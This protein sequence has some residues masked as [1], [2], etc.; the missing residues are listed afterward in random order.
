M[1][2]KTRETNVPT[3]ASFNTSRLTI[4]VDYELQDLKTGKVLATDSNS[5]YGDYVPNS[6]NTKPETDMRNGLIDSITK[7]LRNSIVD[8]IVDIKH[9][10]EMEN[11]LQLAMDSCKIVD[12]TKKVPAPAV[13]KKKSL[14]KK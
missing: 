3:T 4:Y 5:V 1:V 10:A 14:F 11:N 6:T 2:L 9:T 12:L 7:I 13:K 8:E